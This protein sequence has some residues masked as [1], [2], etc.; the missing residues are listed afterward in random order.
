MHHGHHKTALHGADL[1]YLRFDPRK[2]EELLLQ[3]FCPLGL[4]LKSL[5]IHLPIDDVQQQFL[6]EGLG[7]KIM[8]PLA[9]GLNGQFNGRITGDDDADDVGGYFSDLL[10]HLQSA[11]AGHHGIDEQDIKRPL[12]KFVQAVRP[13]FGDLHFQS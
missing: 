5:P 1:L 11:H 4:A 2:P 9:N 12:T 3:F 10:H 13:V 6:G 7:D 8:G